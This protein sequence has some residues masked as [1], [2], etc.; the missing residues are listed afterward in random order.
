MP[1]SLSDIWSN[2]LYQKLILSTVVLLG[3]AGLRRFLGH[4]IMARVPDDSPHVYSLRKIM[5]YLV[6]ALV[7]AVLLMIWV[8]Q[9]GDL[10]VAFGILAAG[11]AF[12]LQEVIGSIAGW[13]TIISG[14]PFTIGDRIETGGIRGDVVDISV[15]RTTLMEIG[16]W[17]GGDHNT[18]RI[19][20]VS[21]AFIF[22]EPLFNYS[23]H[24]RYIWDEL[25]LPVTYESDWQQAIQIMVEAA[26]QHPLYQ[27]LLPKAQEQ[28]RRARR[29]FAIK[30][31]PLEPRVFVRLTDNWIELGLVYP[32]DTDARRSFRSEISQHILAEFATAGI[33]IASQ[34]VAI[35]QFPSTMPQGQPTPTVGRL[36]EE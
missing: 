11:L 22:K 10:S 36:E 27:E 35:V 30:I 2:V 13:V 31:T 34:T 33:V 25:I 14:Q 28:R 29:Q 6:I 5:Q 15:L 19:V 23:R 16:N 7:A 26:R 1:D 18:G 4:L 21:N 8:R 3:A 32:V 24:L 9:L 20:T 17:L 12:A